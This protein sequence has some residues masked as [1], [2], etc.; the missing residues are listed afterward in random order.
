MS[1]LERKE[2][3]VH[4][5][6]ALTCKRVYLFLAILIYLSVAGFIYREWLISLKPSPQV[7]KQPVSEAETN[8]QLYTKLGLRHYQDREFG[9]AEEAFRKAIEYAPERALGYS[10]LGSALIA[11][12]KLDEA[13]AVLEKALSI[14]P[15]L[16]AARYNLEWV[17]AEKAKTRS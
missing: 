8:Y 13:I 15:D 1:T 12:G 2:S 4:A 16:E 17:K 14:D 11:Q 6:S 9:K 5:V 10:N 7:I 3:K